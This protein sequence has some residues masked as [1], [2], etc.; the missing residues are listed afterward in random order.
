MDRHV[1]EHEK[2]L[3]KLETFDPV[4]EIMQEMD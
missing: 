3:D 1:T 4:D 2:V